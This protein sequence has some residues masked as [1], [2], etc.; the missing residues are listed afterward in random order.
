MPSILF[1]NTLETNLTKREINLNLSPNIY[2]KYNSVW[3]SY[4]CIE[5]FNFHYEKFQTYKIEIITDNMMKS[6]VPGTRL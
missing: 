2:A 5:E 3:A 6:H 1:W 4:F